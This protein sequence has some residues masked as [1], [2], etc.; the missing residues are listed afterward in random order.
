M[1]KVYYLK[2]ILLVLLCSCF[3][4]EQTIYKAYI[5]NGSAHKIDI[6]P[7][8]GGYVFTQKVIKL[9]PNE[10]IQVAD[11]WRRGKNGNAGFSSEYFYDIDS[12][13]VVFDDTYK[14][15]HYV[16]NPVRYSTKYFEYFTIGNILNSATYEYEY[17]DKDKYSRHQTYT[18]EFTDSDYEFAKQ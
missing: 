13:V 14:V 17:E 2:L 10:S 18:Y 16:E 6:L 15:S 1:T 5:S 8:K 7:Y 12:A 4:E 3:K 9:Q 11:G